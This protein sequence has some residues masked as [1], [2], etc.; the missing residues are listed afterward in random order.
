[1]ENTLG[2]RVSLDM[3]VEAPIFQTNDSASAKC[4]EHL[5]I[6]AWYRILRAHYH[7]PL[8]QAI[9]FALWLAR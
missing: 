8:F 3:Q 2:I 9:R 4:V 5:S 1:M 7:W 6:L